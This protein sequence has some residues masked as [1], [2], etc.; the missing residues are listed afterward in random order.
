MYSARRSRPGS[1]L[2]ETDCISRTGRRA[3]RSHQAARPAPYPL[4]SPDIFASEMAYALRPRPH[5]VSS[6]RRRCAP[7]RHRVC[8]VVNIERSVER[9]GVYEMSHSR[10]GMALGETGK[11]PALCTAVTLFAAIQ[12]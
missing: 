11:F 3:E 2:D 12:F 5:R 8:S 1:H 10:E 6:D 4:R 7:S 9:E